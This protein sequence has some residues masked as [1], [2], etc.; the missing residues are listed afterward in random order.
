M[1]KVL[2]I[3]DRTLHSAPRVIRTI[4]ALK[5]EFELFTVGITPPAFEVAAHYNRKTIQ[6]GFAYRVFRKINRDYRGKYIPDNY[7]DTGKLYRIKKILDAVE[8]DIVICHECFDVPYM[9]HLKD[10]YQYKLVFNAHEY[11]PLEFDERPEWAGTWQLFY[12]DL[13]RR[14][15]PAVDLMVNVCDSIREKCLDVFQKDSIVIPTAAHLNELP[16]QI[17]GKII[18]LIHHGGAIP[19]RKIE[20]MIRM[21]DILG[22][23]YHLTFML[24]PNV[25]D[26]YQSL[27][28]MARE[29]TNISFIEPVPFRQIVPTL[30]QFDIGIYILPPASFNN[31]IALPNKFFEFIQAKLCIAIGPSPEMKRLSE[32]FEL[33]VVADAFNAESLAQ[34]ISGID[35]DQLLRYKRNAEKAAQT[36]SAEHFGAVFLSA[37]QGLAVGE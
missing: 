4:D 6:E 5:N 20:E 15:L 23:G 36:L 37:I 17:P 7:I 24:M 25:P 21:M 30:N 10:R 28:E 26:Y 3:T 31:A 16:A 9:A 13:Y 19:S 34:K 8:P 11:Y 35:A 12:E 22:A 33:G 32:K 27:Q 2:I 14:F 18:Q 1:K 29:R